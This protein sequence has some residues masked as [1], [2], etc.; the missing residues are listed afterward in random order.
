MSTL[1]Q[2]TNDAPSA[3]LGAAN[4]GVSANIASQQPLPTPLELRARLPAP[5]AAL[6]WVAAA[7]AQAADILAR[8]D[9]RLLVIVGPCSIHDP[10]ASRHY[11]RK[12]QA[13]AE[14]TSDALLLVMRAYFEKPRTALGWKGLIND[15]HLNDTFDIAHGLALARGLLL[16]LAALK[17]PAATE[18]LNPIAPPYLQEL[19]TWTAIGARTTE[20]QTHREM[21][22]GFSSIVGFKNATDGTL[23]PAVNALHAVARPHR[24][25]A[26]DNAGRAAIT[27]SQGNQHA[28]IVLRGGTAGPNYDA[29]AVAQCEQTLARSGLATNIMVDCSHANSGY[30]AQRQLAVADAVAEQIAD[31]NRSIIGLMVESNLVRGRQPLT[32]PEALSYGVSITDA[33]LGWEDTAD[34]IRRLAAKLREPLKAR[35]A[36][37]DPQRLNGA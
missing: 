2:A 28:H 5:A 21:A 9:H 10:T 13:L 12:L 33:C 26:I 19:V 7:R 27:Q 16:D 4:G 30:A 24:F 18:A 32:A 15:P 20:S 1:P 3:T 29:A 17:L 36:I 8:R 14:E 34:L 6:R 25:L 37:V 22:S 31:G 11:A 23:G 35:A